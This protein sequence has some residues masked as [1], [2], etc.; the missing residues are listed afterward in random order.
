MIKTEDKQILG[1]LISSIKIYTICFTKKEII[2][3][4]TPQRLKCQTPTIDIK[5]AAK[6]IPRT[7][8]NHSLIFFTAGEKMVGN[9]MAIQAYEMMQTMLSKTGLFFMVEENA[10]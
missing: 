5:F 4:S 3:T 7:A 10:I 1:I 9:A 8:G 2:Y 6:I